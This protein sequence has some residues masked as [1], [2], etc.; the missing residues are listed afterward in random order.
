VPS[1]NAKYRLHTNGDSGDNHIHFNCKAV[2]DYAKAKAW[3]NNHHPDISMEDFCFSSDPQIS[4]WRRQIP[5]GEDF[6]GWAV[7]AVFNI[8][9]QTSTKRDHRKRLSK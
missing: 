3:K 5:D 2:V 6:A 1:I 7:C 9:S 8:L 4:K